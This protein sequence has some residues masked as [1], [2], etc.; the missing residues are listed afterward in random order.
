MT[1]EATDRSIFSQVSAAG[2]TASVKRAGPTTCLFGQ[3]AVPASLSAEQEKDLASKTPDTYG[4]SSCGSSASANLQGYLE[5]RLR[6]RLDMV[7]SMEYSQTWKQRTTPAG[8]SYLAHTASARRTSDSGCIGWAT[9][10]TRD[11]KDGNCSAANVPVNALLGRQVTGTAQ[12]S[13]PAETGSRGGLNP[14]LPRW[15]MGYPVE[16]CQAAIVAWRSMPTNRRK[17]K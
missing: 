1:S 8:R 9:P 6:V 16:W 13:S 14:A 3:E 15:L 11:W 4:L 10:T 7:G 2:L 5:S 17:P 12:T